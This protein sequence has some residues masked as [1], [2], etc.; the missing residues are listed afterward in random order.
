[1][2]LKNMLLV[3]GAVLILAGVIIEPRQE[4]KDLWEKIPDEEIHTYIE[5]AEQKEDMAVDG[6]VQ[7]VEY[8]EV[9]QPSEEFPPATGEV[10]SFTYDE[11]QLLMRMAQ[12]EAG[13]QGIDGMWLVMSV[14][15]NR[16]RSEHFPDNITDVIYQTAK[17]KKRNCYPSV[18]IRGRWQDR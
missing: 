8:G 14:A 3:L 10:V 13:N 7:E 1:M 16:V 17:T 9:R 2:K 15:V 18:L 12:A 11:A 5:E 4:R 6:P